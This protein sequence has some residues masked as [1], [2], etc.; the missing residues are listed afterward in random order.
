MLFLRVEG[1]TLDEVAERKRIETAFASRSHRKNQAVLLAILDCVIRDDL[2][3]ACVA[4]AEHLRTYR[5]DTRFSEYLHPV[6]YELLATYAERENRKALYP[7]LQEA[8]VA[9]AASPEHLKEVLQANYP[10]LVRYTGQVDLVT[11]KPVDPATFKH[12]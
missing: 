8:D 7:A 10:R 3:G 12:A 9:L 6:V 2:A 4:Y 1:V 11:F 5:G